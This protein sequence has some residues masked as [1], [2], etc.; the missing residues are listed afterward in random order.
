MNS[1][2]A[3]VTLSV[4]AASGVGSQ[5]RHGAGGKAALRGAIDLRRLRPAPRAP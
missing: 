3:R 5:L 2:R 4:T 1:G